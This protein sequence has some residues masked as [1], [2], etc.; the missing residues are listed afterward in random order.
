MS[1]TSNTVHNARL[2]LIATALSNI[3]LAFIVAGFVAPTVSGQVRGGWHALVI[4]AWVGTGLVLYRAAY[5]ALGR[6]RPP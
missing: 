4:L 3:G 5:F 6:L 2:Q 1:G